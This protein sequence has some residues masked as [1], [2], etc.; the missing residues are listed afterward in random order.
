MTK[1][2]ESQSMQQVEKE[3]EFTPEALK[4]LALTR[5]QERVPHE[6]KKMK[7]FVLASAKSRTIMGFILKV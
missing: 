3:V 4:T 1:I 6:F 7:D 5:Y 2:I